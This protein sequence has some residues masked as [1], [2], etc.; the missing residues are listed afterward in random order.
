VSNSNLIHAPW[1]E[2]QVKALNEYQ[3]DGHFHPYTCGKRDTHPYQGSFVI[4]HEDP[5]I[6]RKVVDVELDVL[7][8]TENGWLCPCP[9]CDY[10]QDWA[11]NPPKLRDK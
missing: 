11:H 1:T 10:T 8:A 2:E 5:E 6:D 4:W 3:A 7:I 9:G